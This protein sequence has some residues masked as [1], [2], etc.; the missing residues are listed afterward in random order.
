MYKKIEKDD[1]IFQLDEF[2]KEKYKFSLI[3]QNLKSDEVE[4]YSDEENY[5]FC[6]GKKGYPTWIWT[7]DDLNKDMLKEIEEVIKIYITD[8]KKTEF[9]C[10]EELY[11]LLKDDGFEYL[12]LEDYFEMGFLLCNAVN[13]SRKITEGFID[14]PNE[15]D[16]ETILKYWMDNNKEV[17]YYNALSRNQAEKDVQSF[18]DSNHFF[19]WRN[20]NN[21]V[22]SMAVYYITDNQVRITHVYTPVEERRKGYAANLIYNL[23][24]DLL[25]KNLVPLLYTDCKYDASNKAY[26]S[27]GYEDKGILI[28]FSCS[29]KN[30]I[31]L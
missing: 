29:R 14:V 12:N 9:T 28:N 31:Y 19:V 27:V 17:D 20:D 11:L 2:L 8:N 26:I 5:L 13:T 16:R 15:N 4:L 25:S 1:K 3:F 23:T 7:R 21:K 24:S 6:R 10:K 30:S 22:V 18:Y